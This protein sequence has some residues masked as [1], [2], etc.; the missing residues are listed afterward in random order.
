[1]ATLFTPNKN[2]IRYEGVESPRPFKTP[3][4]QSSVKLGSHIYQNSFS[5]LSKHR[6][7]S[8]LTKFIARNPFEND[9][10]NK[11][12][13]SVIS[14]TVFRK[15]SNTPID[16]PVFSWSIDE[17]ANMKPVKFDDICMEQTHQTDPELEVETQAA[18][19]K[20]FNENEIIPSPWELKRMDSKVKMV[21]YTPTSDSEKENIH[22]EAVKL[23][24]DAWSQTL[25]TLPPE[26]PEHVEA[27]LRPYLTFTQEQNE[28]TEEANLSNSSLRRKLFFNHDEC[29]ESDD[30]SITA[31]PIKN[32]VLLMSCSPPL[33]GMLNFG[34]PL[35]TSTSNLNSNHG[36]PMMYGEDISP[37]K[38]IAE[39]SDS[40]VAYVSPTRGVSLSP[41][42]HY[43]PFTHIHT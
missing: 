15:S 16:S 28:E 24:K 2:R 4:K 42:P 31:S 36:I 41:P 33:S 5:I 19:T 1:M 22:K 26:L 14:P 20:F 43:G 25:L 3:V 27:C 39:T 11:L 17:L 23:K 32:G 34:T 29:L 37:I 18:I 10:R 8:G 6:S 12:H 40:G 35:R 9:L 30:S 13:V 7:P 38:S 21:L